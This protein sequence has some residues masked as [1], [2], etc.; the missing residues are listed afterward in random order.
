MTTALNQ[1]ISRSADRC[2]PFSQLLHKWNG[3]EWTEEC[4][5]VFQQLKD[6]LFRPSIMFRP[7]EKEVLFAYIDVAPYAVSLVLVRL[8]NGVQ[9]P[10]YYVSKS[11]H[12]AEVCYLPLEKAILAMCILSGNSPIIFKLWFEPNFLCRHCSERLVIQGELPSGGR[13]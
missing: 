6:Y 9:R 13:F 12:E 11:L 2:R 1:F 3:F 8:E 4:A 7:K 5:L 10:I